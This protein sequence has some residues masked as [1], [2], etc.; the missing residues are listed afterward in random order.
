MIR[1]SSAGRLRLRLPGLTPPRPRQAGLLAAAVVLIAF[2]F[3]VGHWTTSL[4]TQT[5]SGV[6]SAK[7]CP[8]AAGATAATIQAAINSCA[9]GGT[10]VLAPGTY[11]LTNRL[12]VQSSETITGAGPTA[13][14]LV[15]HARINIFQISAEGV[16]VEN[17]YL[18]TGTYN[19]GIPPQKGN[20]VPSV[21]FSNRS[22]TSVINVTAKAGSGFGMRITGPSPCSSFGT[23]GTVISNVNVTNTG[24]SGFTALDI[25]CTNGAVLT[26]ITIHGD[27]MAL[28]E[29]ENVTLNGMDYAA[30]PYESGYCSHDIYVTGPSNHVLL[31]NI[32]TH[33]G[34]AIQHATQ[35]GVVANLM[36]TNEVYA[37]G[38][39]CTN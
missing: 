25:D 30:G 22:Y 23:H 11:D 32:V 2:G 10:V 33:N 18:D 9:L 31:S 35:A 7:A 38:D 19:P 16:T 36:I 24:A 26:G 8:V 5:S 4:G 29:D 13:T 37:P 20:P 15:Q 3:G 28:Y 27:Y 1:A 12:A 21:L 17:M 34:R 6:L 39:T 14:F